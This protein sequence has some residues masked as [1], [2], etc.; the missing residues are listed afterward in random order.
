M[1]KRKLSPGARIVDAEATLRAAAR[2]MKPRCPCS[3]CVYLRALDSFRMQTGRF[4]GSSRRPPRHTLSRLTRRL[5]YRGSRKA[6]N[7]RKRILHWW[8]PDALDELDVEAHEMYESAQRK[9]RLELILDNALRATAADGRHT[10]V[11]CKQQKDDVE[12]RHP[13]FVNEKGE[14]MTHL[15]RGEML[16]LGCNKHLQRERP[17]ALYGVT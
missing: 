9:K 3:V 7:A 1:T 17:A 12:L 4:V 5:R 10:C 2:G 14:R 8:G 6:R 16:C 13:T 15:T 11:M